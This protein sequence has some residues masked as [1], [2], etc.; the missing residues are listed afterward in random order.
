MKIAMKMYSARSYENRPSVHC[1]VV[2][3]V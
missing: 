3:C 2:W 1:I